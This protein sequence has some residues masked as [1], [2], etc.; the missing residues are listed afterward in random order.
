MIRP[1]DLNALARRLRPGRGAGLRTG[2]WLRPLPFALAFGVLARDS[3]VP[4]DPS[5]ANR[6][7]ALVRALGARG[8]RATGASEVRW[9]EAEAGPWPGS[10]P[11]ARAVVRAPS[12]EGPPVLYV[13][14]TRLSPEGVLL[15]VGKPRRLTRSTGLEE[16]VPAVSGERVATALTADG[17]ALGVQLV[18]LGGEAPLE[19]PTWTAL[20]RAQNGLTNVQETGQW[21]GLGRRSVRLVP[22]SSNVS[23]AFERGFLVVRGEGREGRIPA[24]A[25]RV[26]GPVA[27]GAWLRPEPNEKGQ[28]GNLVTWAVDRARASEA[29]GD[30]RMQAVK[31]V[32][33]DALDWAMRAKSKVSGD[34]SAADVARDLGDLRAPGVVAAFTDPDT[35][36]P[37]AAIKP[38]LDKPMPGE[39]E[40]ITLDRDPFVG[41]NP[42]AP[43][44]FATTYLRAD[45]ERPYSR[46]Y[47][48]IW[49][50]RQV[51]LHPAAG[52]AEPMDATG[53]AGP[54]LIPR[55]PKTMRRLVGAFNGGF[56]A[57]HGEFG[58][59]AD[60]HV[61]L[62][63]KPY[64]ATVAELRDGSTAF[65]VWPASAEVPEQI[66]GY[67][68]NLTPLV[69]RG[70]LNPYG[71]TWWGGTAPGSTDLVHT[72]RSGLC[73][74]ADRFVAYF[75]G[76][77]I[78]AMVLGEAMQQARCDVGMHLDM[79][80]GH[81][82]L[83]FYHAAPEA[84]WV[85][86][87]RPYQHDWEAENDLR[88]MPGWRFRGRRMVRG[89]GLM[90]FPRYI[91]REGRDF[92]YLTL[93]PV[94]PG[95]DLKAPSGASPDDASEGRWR[96]RGL[97]QQGFPFALATTV[98]RAPNAP[99]AGHVRLVKIDPRTVRPA[100]PGVAPAPKGPGA[101]VLTWQA[102]PMRRPSEPALWFGP[103]GFSLGA[104]APPGAK[105]LVGGVASSGAP[106]LDAGALL[107][108]DPDGMLVYAEM[109]PGSAL[110]LVA[111]GAEA[112][113]A[114]LGCTS[115][116]WLARSLQ[117]L[118]GGTTS[119]GGAPA[120]A[121]T[122]PSIAFVRAEAPG[123]R[124]LFDDTPVVDIKQWYPLQSKRIRYFR[125]PNEG[126]GPTSPSSTAAAPA[127]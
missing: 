81:T 24:D 39:G 48:T 46:I 121:P 3:G 90:N 88:G 115:R 25:A 53:N 123:G 42:G 126:T 59:M 72:A 96:V 75:Y 6:S 119:L 19:G 57:M 54:G 127:P 50:P 78:S 98:L 32:A 102:P 37:P 89:M 1:F 11:R 60:G 38:V 95:A 40:W 15:D 76:S 79:N 23:L 35:G 70:K 27:D 87:G 104:Q 18:D 118:L 30:E 7:E 65:G 86:F 92:F 26:D 52:A 28:I 17:T 99:S 124:T 117:P 44:A 116:L 103:A 80:A 77:E 9:L 101:L 68:Q 111:S 29:I 5:A 45:R 85:P 56:Q 108:I 13:V 125:K 61:Y 43:P 51:E 110:S 106:P 74:T 100:D 82:G 122:E 114:E 63:P 93:R 105:A 113:L 62:P 47:V 12:A 109:E 67:R 16:S 107:G 97:P 14:P 41:G 73:L 36:W 84:E 94:L 21:R 22:P 33:F 112:L 31:A 66:V 2:P 83:E 71:R 20:A 69:L 34:T 4:V 91:N 55:T 64:G 120:P 8:L 10:E 49:D 58:M